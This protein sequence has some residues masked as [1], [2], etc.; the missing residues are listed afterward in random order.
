[1]ENELAVEEAMHYYYF[2][3][4][5][6]LSSYAPLFPYPLLSF[7]ASSFTTYGVCEE[8]HAGSETF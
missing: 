4:D 3:E 2:P 6:K 1:V 5:L 8:R 7:V